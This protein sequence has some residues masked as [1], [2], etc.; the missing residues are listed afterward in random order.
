MR[1]V[2]CL[3]SYLLI[4]I[5]SEMHKSYLNWQG[6]GNVHFQIEFV[7]WRYK[8]VNWMHVLF[9]DSSLRFPGGSFICYLMRKFGK[10]LLSS[11][12]WLFS[13]AA[14]MRL[15]WMCLNFCLHS[16]NVIRLCCVL[17]AVMTCSRCPTVPGR[18]SSSERRMWLWSAGGFWP[19]W[20]WMWPSWFAPF[21]CEDSI[22]TWPTVQEITWRHTGSNSSGSLFLPRL[23]HAC[24]LLNITETWNDALSMAAA[25]MLFRSV[26]IMVSLLALRRSF[27]SSTDR[28]AWSWNSRPD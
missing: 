11:V 5:Q 25:V 21:C 16:G 12:Y 2:L 3:R 22:R 26:M 8:P 24:V 14:F 1:F 4:I 10:P 27:V 9:Y 15:H 19:V 28:A 7:P 20:G 17:F 18:L 6:H 23:V 13:L